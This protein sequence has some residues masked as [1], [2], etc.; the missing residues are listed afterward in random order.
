MLVPDLVMT[1]TKPPAERPYSAVAPWFTTISSSMASWLK[2]N[3]GRC[4]PRCSPKNGLLK[5]A[6][7]TMK[8]LKMPRWPAMFSSSPSGPCE[9]DAPGVSSVRFTKLRP[10][11]G[12]PSTTSSSTRC[13]LVTPVVS[14]GEGRLAATLTV[15][16]ATTRKRMSTSSV[17]PTRRPAPSMRSV[18]RPAV[19]AATVRSYVP[20]GSSA[21]TNVPA[22]EVS[23]VVT[24]SVS[25]CWMTM[26][27]PASG[28]PS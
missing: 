7:S 11:L 4:P 22:A 14:T 27:A 18:P 26:T 3:A 24:R 10:S 13:A 12:R 16:A 28:A 21:R 17:S 25:R 2:V 1:L 20:G 9:T 15:S 5:S 19:A 8:L 6:P 23:T